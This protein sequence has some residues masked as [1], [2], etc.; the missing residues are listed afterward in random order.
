MAIHNFSIVPKKDYPSLLSGSGE[1]GE[2]CFL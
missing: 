2:T 1:V